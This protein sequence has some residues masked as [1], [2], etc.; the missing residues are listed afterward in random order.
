VPGVQGGFCSNTNFQE[1]QTQ[2]LEI[3]SLQKWLDEVR[4]SEAAD[5][6]PSLHAPQPKQLGNQPDALDPSAPFNHVAHRGSVMGGWMGS[7]VLGS[8]RGAAYTGLHGN[9][10]PV[11]SFAGGPGQLGSIRTTRAATRVPGLGWVPKPYTM[12][13][14]SVRCC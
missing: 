1:K 12:R 7:S 8:Y 3:N 14:I 5:Q 11:G 2:W 4:E 13:V 9:R 6:V 10:V